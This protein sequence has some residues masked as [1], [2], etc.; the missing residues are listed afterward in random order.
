[1]VSLDVLSHIVEHWSKDMLVMLDHVDK[2]YCIAALLSRST[3]IT[4][5]SYFTILI[6]FLDTPLYRIF[7]RGSNLTSKDVHKTLSVFQS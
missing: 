7:N 3:V 5:Q 1:M 2:C 6:F 4:F